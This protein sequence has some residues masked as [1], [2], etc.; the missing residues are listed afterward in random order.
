MANKLKLHHNGEWFT[1]TN[2]S[3]GN[4][5]LR[6][7]T[8]TLTNIN[9]ITTVE[10]N[11]HALCPNACAHCHENDSYR[12]F[13]MQELDWEEFSLRYD[14]DPDALKEFWNKAGNVTSVKFNGGD[15]LLYPKTH[16]RALD[17]MT[18]RQNI[19]LEYSTSL[20]HEVNAEV[21]KSW[22]EFKA[23]KLFVS[24]DV[25]EKYWSYF[26]YG[27]HWRNI[28]ENIEEVKRRSSAEVHGVVTVNVLTM[29][30]LFPVVEYFVDNNMRFNYSFVDTENQ[31]SCIYMPM[32]LKREAALQLSRSKLKTREY[33]DPELK[34]VADKAFDTIQAHMFST[35]E[36]DEFWWE[37]LKLFSDLDRVYD[38]N[39]Y[40]LSDKKIKHVDQVLKP[41]S[42]GV[43]T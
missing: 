42:D 6:E 11:P 5:K 17:N 35:Y 8:D 9:K 39:I 40:Q 1:D 24:I 41:D 15:P 28:L 2:E 32:H 21:Y 20:S 25:S 27:S 10:Y 16:I 37:T 3:Q 34:Q 36:S 14:D 30:D 22:K 33:K 4:W 19:T 26:R 7:I 43:L 12:W 23:V 29:M 38:M 18:N 31:L 13:K